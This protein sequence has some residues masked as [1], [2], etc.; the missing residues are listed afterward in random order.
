MGKGD[1]RTRRG[2]IFAGSYGKTRQKG[3]KKKTGGSAKSSE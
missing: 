3:G 2:K 1:K